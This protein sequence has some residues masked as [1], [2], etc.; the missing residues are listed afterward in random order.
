[1][2]NAGR[3]K[4]Q[5]SPKDAFDLFSQ[6]GSFLPPIVSRGADLYCFQMLKEQEFIYPC[7]FQTAMDE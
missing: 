4:L 6:Q 5:G 3:L 2:S 1:M 7:T